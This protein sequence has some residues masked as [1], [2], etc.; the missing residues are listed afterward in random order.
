MSLLFKTSLLFLLRSVFKKENII[1]FVIASL[2]FFVV[3]LYIIQFVINALV[4]T[5]FIWILNALITSLI[6]GIAI[7]TYLNNSSQKTFWLLIS[8]ILLLIQV[9]GFFIHKFYI[10]NIAI[11]QIVIL[12][13][14][15]S[16][17]TFYRF[18]IFKDNEGLNNSTL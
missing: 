13:Y 1:A 7:I 16:Q 9:G 18:M 17:F 4:D 3:Y 6:G 14:T 15:F 11:Y 2:P 5:Y 12:A 8:A 10:Y